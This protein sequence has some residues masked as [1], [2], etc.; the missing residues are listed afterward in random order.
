M[1]DTTLT[2]Q[3]KDPSWETMVPAAVVEMIKTKNLF[4]V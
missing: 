1:D 2:T 3:R 4:A